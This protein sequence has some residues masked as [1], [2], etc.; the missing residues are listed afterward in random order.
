MKLP[1]RY[2]RGGSRSL[3]K[4]PNSQENK[5][6]VRSFFRTPSE[7]GQSP[8]I[9]N[10]TTP[11]TPINPRLTRAPLPAELVLLGLEA[12]VVVAVPVAVFV[13]VSVVLVEVPEV[14]PVLVAV[15]VVLV[16]VPEGLADELLILALATNSVKDDDIFKLGLTAKTIPCWQ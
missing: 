13:P 8:K 7:N 5:V 14:V 10:P 16:A 1:E 4:F 2:E 9:T 6:F 15:P 3:V 12:L 11:R